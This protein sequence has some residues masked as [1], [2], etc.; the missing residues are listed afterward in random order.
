M[1]YIRPSYNKINL[2]VLHAILAIGS[3][4]ASNST[5]LGN[6][7]IIGTPSGQ[8]VTFKDGATHP[9]DNIEVSVDADD[10]G[11]INVSVNGT[12]LTSSGTTT[13]GEAGVGTVNVTSGGVL[14]V[15][16]LTLGSDV[17]PASGTMNLTGE[18]TTYTATG[19]T[20]IGDSGTGIWN[21]SSGATATSEDSSSLGLSEDGT[22]T[23][24]IT[25]ADTRWDNQKT[26]YVG[27]NGSGTFYVE[28]SAEVSSKGASIGDQSTST[29]NAGISGGALWRIDSDSLIIGNAGTGTLLVEGGANTTAN[30][31]VKVGDQA[32]GTGTLTVTGSGSTFIVSSG[33][34]LG[35]DGSASLILQANG[36][37][38]TE[39]GTGTLHLAANSNS[40]GSIIIGSEEGED[41]I[42]P[43]SLIASSIQLANGEASIVFNHSASSYIFTPAITQSGTGTGSVQVYS[44]TT[45]LVGTS[46]NYTG[47]LQGVGGELIV[48]GGADFSN[49]NSYIGYTAGSNST[50]TISGASHNARTALYAG[51]EG[52]GIVNV[53]AGA[54][55]GGGDTEIY[56]GYG[57]D[58]T[59]TLNVTETGSID[60]KS[61][62]LVVGYQGDGTVN[63]NTDGK[64]NSND[65]SIGAQSA[66]TGTVNLSGSGSQW[67]MVSDLTVGDYGTGT[68]SI[69]GGAHVENYNGHIGSQI[70]GTGEVLVSGN[71][72]TWNNEE[73]L[74]IGENGTGTLTVAFDANVEVSEDE[75]TIYLAQKSGSIGVL[76]IGAATGDTAVTAGRITA[77][78]V[79]MGSGTASLTFNHTAPANN[80]LVFSSNITGTGTVN[81][82]AGNMQMTGNWGSNVITTIKPNSGDGGVWLFANGTA[83][84][85]FTVGNGG[86]LGG[87]GTVGSVTFEAGS[88]AA[89][90]DDFGT[91]GQLTVAGDLIL[92][93]SGGGALY[94]VHIIGTGDS[95]FIDVG[96]TATLSDTSS[97]V[98]FAN[99]SEPYAKS[100]SYDILQAGALSGTVSAVTNGN[101]P[102]YLVPTLT[103]STNNTVVLTVAN[104][105][106]AVASVAQTY[107]QN[108][109]AE[110]VDAL[111]LQS[112]DDQL[113]AARAGASVTELIATYSPVYSGLM[114]LGPSDTRR[115]LDLLGG[116]IYAS[117]TSVML[118]DS[119]FLREAVLAQQVP[120]KD[121]YSW[122]QGFG[123]WADWDGTGN[124]AA[125]SRSTGGFFTGVD[126]QVA[127]QL[128]VGLLAGYSY[129][130]YDAR[131][132]SSTAHANSLHLGSY[133]T[134]QGAW[135]DL[136]LG[137]AYSLGFVDTGRTMAYGNFYDD[138]GGNYTTG[139]LQL[140]GQAAHTFETAFAKLTPFAGG[141][142]VAQTATSFQEDGGDAA[143]Q[144]SPETETVYFSNIGG[145]IEKD[146][147]LSGY[148]FSLKLG[149]AWQHLFGDDTAKTRN[150]LWGQSYSS[151][152]KGIALSRN[153]AH[154]GAGLSLN[155][156]DTIRASLTYDGLFSDNA[157]DNG[158]NGTLRIRF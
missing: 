53:T 132:R 92:G 136:H 112:L 17:S 76:N 68:L 51:Y 111:R 137:A 39:S 5:S 91:I 98:L 59:G 48:T 146:F 70:S 143:L 127:A 27:N 133:S 99:Q 138:P 157:I 141:A 34:S 79:D 41:A 95:D 58:A 96:G 60:I 75:K 86:Y 153:T 49:D 40:T 135:A 33:T 123:A 102:S 118:E 46:S 103:V 12:T 114:F 3:I 72:S 62:T 2:K 108:E 82:E 4:V 131:H 101:Y 1:I 78:T 152:V 113:A 139:T 8:S 156:T 134:V 117:I 18:N 97:V 10:T 149:A 126:G 28:E 119:R 115:A 71:G 29:G 148:T 130:S 61:K 116:D 84:G 129:A 36:S 122:A 147:Q 77:D 63:I 155:L 124:A 50:F 128:R 56:V 121:R 81:M 94:N 142:F 65:G 54:N 104:T 7:L 6:D 110:A 14:S 16:S 55:A 13:V 66:S 89:P 11:V 31:G 120:D 83:N 105:Q 43:G 47:D 24:T 145:R 64:I 37:Y 80:A 45:N 154:L 107:N 106:A 23:A 67:T 9:Y 151:H 21:M 158:L 150:T 30:G 15:V 125:L 73:A 22:G 69:T 25:G 19:T 52:T 100:T 109:M 74:I 87:S 35:I 93:A 26:L 44:G 85:D 57:A 38:I 32:G 20:Q 144:V 42:S 140:F 90:G 88:Q